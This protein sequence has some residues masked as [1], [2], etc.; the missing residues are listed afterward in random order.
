MLLYFEEIEQ[1]VNVDEISRVYQYAI[2]KMEVNEDIAKQLE[3]GIDPNK[4]VFPEPEYQTTILLKD[5][6]K[7]NINQPIKTVIEEIR[8]NA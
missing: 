5:G 8:K 7:L 2:P 4:L 3:E 1:A 6:N